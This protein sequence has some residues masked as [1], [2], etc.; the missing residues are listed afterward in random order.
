MG[1]LAIIAYINHIQINER[2]AHTKRMKIGGKPLLKF[3]ALILCL[4]KILFPN[5]LF[6]YPSL[7]LH[8]FKIVMLTPLLVI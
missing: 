3:D 7:I 2:E 6:L 8:D 1:N 4:S 5:L